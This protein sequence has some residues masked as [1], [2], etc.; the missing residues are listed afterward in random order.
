MRDVKLFTICSMIS[1]L[2]MTRVVSAEEIE[3]KPE[4]SNLTFELDKAKMFKPIAALETWATYSTGEKSGDDACSD[5]L[6]VN[7]RRFRFGA[8]GQPYNFVKY[9]FQLH[10]DRLGEDAFAATKGSDKG[11]VG[12]WNAYTSFKL[13]RHS[14]ALNLHV[15]YFWAAVSRDFMTS[16]WAVSS[17]DKAYS[18][19][20]LRHFITGAGNGI[21]SGIA[22]GGIQNFDHTSLNYRVGV[23][24]PTAYNSGEQCSR[25]YTGR[26]MYSIGDPEQTKYKYM[27]SGNQWTKR[28]GITLGMGASSQSDGFLNDSVKF[29]QSWS[30]GGDVLINYEGISVTGEYYLMGRT[31]AEFTSFEATSLNLRVSYTMRVSSTFVEPAISFDRYSASGSSTL[32][33]FI[34]DDS[35][36]DM[37]VNWYLNKDKLKLSLH[38]VMQD[39]SASSNVGDYVGMACQVKL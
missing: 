28:K 30:W 25:L 21:S 16:P 39:G 24:E 17:F 1:L 7:L 32:Y 27:L 9:C 19:Y 11:V 6:D 36:F 12:L 23:Y 33:K 29:D 18:I 35:T 20:Y 3:V 31:A 34:G 15:G 2:N 5:R 26:L 38:Y 8:S 14:D 4:K 22:L 37:G 13:L 10:F